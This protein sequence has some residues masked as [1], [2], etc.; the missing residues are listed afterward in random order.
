MYTRESKEQQYSFMNNHFFLKP[1]LDENHKKMI[2]F[3]QR[4]VQQLKEAVKVVARK[5]R[6]SRKKARIKLISSIRTF[7]PLIEELLRQQKARFI[8]QPIKNRIVS[9]WAPHIRPIRRGKVP[10]SVEFGPKV[11]LYLKNGFLFPATFSF[12]NT[13][14]C[15]LLIPTIQ[16]YQQQFG[17]IPTQLGTD[18]GCYSPDNIAYCQRIGVGKIAIEKRGYHSVIEKP[19]PY[20]KYLRRECCRI[21]AKIS[22]GKRKLGLD[23][24]GYRICGGEEMWIRSALAEM[25]LNYAFD[26]S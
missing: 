26:S 7:L 15:K 24:T 21:E 6:R 22:L 19:P 17:H 25:N 14:D 23:R 4:N 5:R 20:L 2:C 1:E 3:V 8:E 11:A 9:L 16:E 13:N 18:R 10:V 12:E